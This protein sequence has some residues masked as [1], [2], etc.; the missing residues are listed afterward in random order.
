M[1][2]RKIITLMFLCLLGAWL[3]PSRQGT[4]E[5]QSGELKPIYSG[6]PLMYVEWT[7]DSQS[8]IFIDQDS[9]IEADQRGTPGMW[10]GYEPDTKTLKEIPVSYWRADLPASV[11]QN[12]SN[13]SILEDPY[14][15]AFETMAYPSPDG[16]Y[17][18]YI[19][20]RFGRAWRVSLA[21]LQ[22]GVTAP[23]E[24]YA[25]LVA[26]SLPEEVYRVVWNATSTTFF[27]LTRNSPDVPYEAFHV[28][29][30]G[31]NV[32][33]VQTHKLG[34]LSRGGR[35]Y[36]Q[37]ETF[38]LASDGKTALMLIADFTDAGKLL[39]K[40]LP[41]FLI[42]WNA[43]KPESSQFIEGIDGQDV[44]AAS[45]A[46][47][48]ESKLLYVNDVGLL[49]YDL[50]TGQTTVLDTRLAAQPPSIARFSPDGRWVALVEQEDSAGPATLYVVATGR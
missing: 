26:T 47:G 40:K 35:L 34:A 4:V 44:I 9:V 43:E 8:L 27:V 19:S 28:S 21:D 50:R 25:F 49:E 2:H 18:V 31:A 10:Q 13:L 23:T 36:G 20:E 33:E 1:N 42:L 17:L 3:E 24:A 15:P 45:F 30:F 22:T 37:V 16:R 7:V 12:L 29:G 41:L 5:A 14:L 46:P 32:R 11:Q 48:N 6:F 39:P 38:S